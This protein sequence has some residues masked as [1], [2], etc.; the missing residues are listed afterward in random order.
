[1]GFVVFCKI[2][3]KKKDQESFEE[4]C[5]SSL[6]PL[7]RES[8]AFRSEEQKTSPVQTTQCSCKKTKCLKLY[9]PCLAHSDYCSGCSCRNCHN[10][11]NRPARERALKKI[12]NRTPDAF[13]RMKGCTCSKIRCTKRYCECYASGLP[14]TD[15][16]K[17]VSCVNRQNPVHRS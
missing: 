3:E 4:F 7:N 11:P 16:C 6:A 15:R 14:C 8:S 9:C 1:M 2:M 5:I 17:C 12:L 13:E 10:K